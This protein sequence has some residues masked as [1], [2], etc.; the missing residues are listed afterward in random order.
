MSVLVEVLEALPPLELRGMA[1]LHGERLARTEA[2]EAVLELL[3]YRRACEQLGA[4]LHSV[5]ALPLSISTADW[6][7]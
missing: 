3:A 7:R 5:P 4:R 1:L 2:R 6:V